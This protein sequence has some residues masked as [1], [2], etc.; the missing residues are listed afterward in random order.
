MKLETFKYDL[1]EQLIAQQTI[2]PKHCCRMMYANPKTEEIKDF[3]FYDFNNFID[4]NDVIVVNDTRVLSAVLRGKRQNGS[5]IEI[6]MVSRKENNVWDCVVESRK[7]VEIGER[8][9]FGENSELVGKVINENWCETGWLIK[10]SINNGSVEDEIKK[11]GQY[12]L[13]LHLP[14]KLNDN[15]DYQT[16]YSKV[17]GSLQPPTA[18]LH[19]TDKYLNFLSEKGIKIIKITQHVGRLDKRLENDNIESHQMYEEHYD[20][21]EEAASEINQARKNGGRIIGIGTTVTRTLET[22]VDDDGIIHSGSGWT[23][24]YIYPGFK[25]KA[26]DA[27]LTNFQSPGITTL[28]LACAFG[29]TE[30]TLNAYR[31]AVRRNYRFLEFGDCIFFEN[32]KSHR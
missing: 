2:Y 17:E 23:K 16:V 32:T 6:K 11:I 13:P 22:V 26:I 31:E 10:F 5:Q 4:S 29:G 1:P 9:Y 8:L 27:L 30:F 25:F 15:E 28:I 18:G 19:F 21:S 24:L 7:G 20:V 14:Q 12:F 3:H